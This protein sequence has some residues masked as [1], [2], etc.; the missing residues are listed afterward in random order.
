MKRVGL[1]I[2]VLGALIVATCIL[3]SYLEIQ[4]R[5]NY[6][7]YFSY[8]LHLDVT[9]RRS[10]IGIPGQVNMYEAKL[11]NFTI[12]PKSI[13]GCSYTSD[14]MQSGMAFPYGV[15][16]WNELT[17]SWDNVIYAD[18][19][20][21]CHPVPLSMGDTNRVSYTL[22]PTFSVEAVEPEAT[23]A[24]EPFAH[25]DFARFFVVTRFEEGGSVQTVSSEQ[26][27]IEDNVSHDD[28]QYRVKH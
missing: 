11:F 10:S 15:Q 21:F 9:S 20:V 5:Y 13:I 2:K 28:V 16:R 18:T 25:G 6:G 26:F 8:G 4:H 22:W 24:R 3:T 14:T 12:I 17:K 23:G 7:H 1:S 19:D 27:Q